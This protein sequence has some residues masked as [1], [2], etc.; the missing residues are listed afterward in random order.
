MK[1]KYA[2]MKR[3]NSHKISLKFNQ[4]YRTA[5]WD[6]GAKSFLCVSR[7]TKK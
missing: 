4:P 3:T 5:F 2:I 1:L 7:I 6:Y